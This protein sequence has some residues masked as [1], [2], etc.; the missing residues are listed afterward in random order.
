MVPPE[1]RQERS[2]AHAPA[3]G[4]PELSDIANASQIAAKW[5]GGRDDWWQTG[6]VYQIYPR[7]FADGNGDGLGDLPGIIEHLDHLN[8]GTPASLGVDA[9]WLSPIYPSPDFD[10]GYDVSSYVDVDPRYGTLADF[11]ALVAA[12]HARGIKVVIDLVLNHTS[13]LHPWFEA[14][15]ASRT[16]PYADWYIW[17]DS[18]GRSI[19]GGRRRPNNWRSFFGGSA[20]TWDEGRE[21]FYMHTFLPEQPDL[22]WRNPD[23]RAALMDVVRTWLQRGVGRLPAGRLQRVLQGRVAPLEPA[24][25]RA[26]AGRV[27][28][29]APRPRP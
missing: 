25:D 2:Y 3:T 24:A 16:G 5:R 9:I 12:S 1:P 17:A 8:D 27:V 21:Q 26:K 14:S 11:D 20:W 13:H 29:A 28:L 7:S 19:T 18:P 10:F 23:V 4:T 6:V 15:R 22:N